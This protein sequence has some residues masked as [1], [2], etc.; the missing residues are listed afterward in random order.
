MNSSS[1]TGLNAQAPRAAGILVG[2]I[3]ATLLL[4]YVIPYGRTI[5]YPLVL[6]S[7]LVHEMGHGLAAHSRAYESATDATTRA[8]F[9]AAIGS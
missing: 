1:P 9:E 4:W 8:A 5:A 7:T 3:I 2:S 6:L